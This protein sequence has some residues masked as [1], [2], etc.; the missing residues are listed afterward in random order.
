M[1]DVLV[2]I[3]LFCLSNRRSHILQIFQ[4]SGGRRNHRVAKHTTNNIPNAIAP[5]AANK[6]LIQTRPGLKRGA[7]TQQPKATQRTGTEAENPRKEPAAFLAWGSVKTM[8]PIPKVITTRPRPRTNPNQ[9]I[10][11][12]PDRIP[13]E[14]IFATWDEFHLSVKQKS[15]LFT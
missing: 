9:G 1:R 12:R 14:I 8:H 2:L 3:C 4:T 6:H 10:Q 7:I 5:P 13:F 15:Y 11:A